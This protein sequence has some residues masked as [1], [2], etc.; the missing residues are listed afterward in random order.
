MNH[1]FRKLKL[2]LLFCLLAF[3]AI[4]QTTKRPNIVFILTDD[5]R[6]DMLGCTG[7]PIVQ[8]PHLDQLAKDGIL[9]TNAH[10]T[11]AICT[12]SRVSIFLSQ[13]ERKHGVNFNSGT[14]VALEAW[15]NA[16]PMLLR[17]NG[18]YTGYIGKNH[19]PVGNGGYESGV[20]ENSFDYWYAAHGHLRFYP[21]ERHDIFKN[22]VNNTQVEILNEGVEDFFS[23]EQKLEGAKHFLENRPSGQP[24]CLSLCFNLPHGAST[25]TMELR[26]SDPIIYRDL[27]RNIVIPLPENYLEKSAITSPRLPPEI[28]FAEERQSGYNYVDNKVAVKERIIRSMQA[29]TGI[30]LLVGNLRQTLK[31]KGLD[32]NTIIIF[33]SDH[34]LFFGEFGLGGKALCYETCTR[35]PMII[36]NPMVPEASKGLISEELVQTIDI[37]PTILNYADIEPPN[38]YQGRPLNNLIRGKS[39]IP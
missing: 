3:T 31:E 24:F 21:K 12:P 37:A 6:Y 28:H 15:D 1:N 35:V 33:T 32:E 2:G 9:F 22:A 10:V 19:A 7:N 11:S 5:H 29:V 20:M 4:A 18:Y 34:G 25:S 13:F 8:T 16:Y 17:K 26:E 36:Y 23:N 38:S 14:S 39:E 27:Y 30:D